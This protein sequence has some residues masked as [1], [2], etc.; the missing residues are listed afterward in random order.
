M[1]DERINK[2][3]SLLVNFSCKVQK[4]EKVLIEAIGIDNLLP[5]ALVKEVYK[6][7]GYP[8]V[9]LIDPQIRR[10]LIKGMTKEEAELMAKHESARM[11][12]MDAYIGIRG[13][14]NAYENGDLPS[15]QKEIELKYYY[16]PVHYD[17]RVKH[18]KWVILRYPTPS[19]AQLANMSTEAFE[20][21]YFINNHLNY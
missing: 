6:A 3:A 18:T 20:E 1:I 16:T 13:G 12:D 5:I 9:H 11:D 21:F 4:G 15:E 8:I 19:F 10:E 17:R 14:L 7:G 2:L